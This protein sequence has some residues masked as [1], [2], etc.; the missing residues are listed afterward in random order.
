MNKAGYLFAALLLSA[1]TGSTGPAGLDTG[2]ISG[3]VKDPTGAAIASASVTTT[4]AS[5]PATTDS[6]GNFTLASIPIGS[7]T[8]TFTKSGYQTATLTAV[9][10]AAGVTN[11][12]TV[13][14]PPML[15]TTGTVSGKVLGRQG[16]AQPSSP[17]AGATV[18][19][20]PLTAMQCTKSQADGS[21]VL[22][23]ISPGPV[24]IWVT[25]TGF[26]PGELKEAAAV[27]A[28]NTVAG[29][30]IT[31]SGSPTSSATYIGAAKCVV[32][33]S[34]LEGGLVTA[35]QHSAHGSTIAHM[36]NSLDLALDSVD[37]A[38]WPAAPASCATSPAVKDSL[39]KATEPVS[40]Q[41]QE[42]LLARWA[43][44]CPG[45]PQFAMAFDANGNGVIDPGET[46]IPVQGTIGGV[47]TDAGQCGNGGLLPAEPGANYPC[48]ANFLSSGITFTSSQGYWQQEYLVRIGPG[49]NKPAWVTWDTTN[50]PLDM[51]AL[52]LAWNQR[53]QVWI[54]GPDYNPTQA[55]TYAKVCGGCH[56]TGPAIT[57]D[58]NGNVTNYVAGSQNIACE[59]CH[60]PG[61]D[62]FANSGN[63]QFIINPAYISAQAQDEM[64]GQCHSNAVASVQPAGVFDFAWNNQAT[65][66]GGNFIPGLQSL[67]NFAQL[68]AYGNS[69]DYWPGGVFTSL[70]HMSYID[71][72]VS[73]HNTNPYEKV[74]CT[75]CHEGHSVAGGPYQ[76][77]RVNP[78]SG[79]QYLFQTNDA[80][81]RNDVLCLACH[82]TH[83]DFAS[84]AL[85]DTA[86]Y[87]VSQGGATQKNGVAWT[88]TADVQAASTNAIVTAVDAHMLAKAG[89]PAFFDPNGV[90][91]GQPVG[92][93]SSCHLAKTAWTATFF[94][95]LD[96]NGKTANVIGDVSSHVFKVAQAQ[97]SL[98]SIPSATSWQGVMPN[99]CGSCH[100]EYRFGM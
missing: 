18:C 57:V 97:D 65:P 12:V 95:G 91:N 51:L 71:V 92:R 45:E 75:D 33:H 26:L 16:V 17:V 98:A 19:I 96:A 82:A 2:S 67:A 87:H 42:V 14:M 99:A 94:S 53:T 25:A 59:R 56:E 93:C 7:Y 89:M 9:G 23:G 47:A 85:E 72:Q 41:Q 86:N 34:L 39:V 79:D 54:L 24:F 73:A 20:E 74:T 69:A 32:C 78:Q 4:P 6:S 49:P 10:V 83:G 38:G 81:L 36:P 52:P 46:V 64:C 37:Q 31:L 88:P 76:F 30:S 55:G 5:T 15:V 48:S 8:L 80:V 27:T 60:G 70:D 77:Q 44:N 11:Q 61:S 29:I 84:V 21:F 22:A 66:G 1:C 28:G 100:K 62:H 35:W 68:P 3:T 43:A 63:S 40:G 50:T 90:T 13:T 58:A